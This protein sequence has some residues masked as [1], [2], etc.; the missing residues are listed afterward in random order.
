MTV[1]IRAHHLLCMLTY[2]GKGYT[3]DF[4][5]NY[6]AVIDRL[7][8]GEGIRLVGGPD[9]ICAPMLNE[10]VCHCHNDSVRERDNL[11]A[12]AIGSVVGRE[13]AP[14]NLLRLDAATTQQLR[15][16]F[17]AASIRTAC[18]SCE[19]QALCTRIARN[20]YRGCQLAPPE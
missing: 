5:R 16:A 14:G 2:L 20:N 10:N 15:D 11:A 8:A 12:Q 13:L 4:V 7:N 9:E 3:E 1:S 17:A 6:S 18:T 19:W